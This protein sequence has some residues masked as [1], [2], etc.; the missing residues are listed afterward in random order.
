MIE[1]D[2][3]EWFL[4]EN[5]KRTGPFTAAQLQAFFEQNKISHTSQVSSSHM[6]GNWISI[7]EL[8]HGTPAASK[9]SPTPA[10]DF[11]PP[12]RPSFSKEHGPIPPPIE[13]PDPLLSLF[14]ALQ[15]AKERKATTPTRLETPG[16]T[17]LDSFKIPSFLWVVASVGTV[18]GVT[19]W[20]LF[21]GLQK[22][23]QTADVA[24]QQDSAAP[25][26][27]KSVMSRSVQSPS[28]PGAAPIARPIAKTPVRAIANIRPKF[29]PPPSN[30]RDR[31]P[32]PE[33][34]PPRYDYGEDYNSD[35]SS[36]TAAQQQQPG[37]LEP[38]P[39]AVN[40]PEGGAP[41]NNPENNQGIAPPEQ[42]QN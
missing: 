25:A 34:D 27:V 36:T 13:R 26:S 31:E 41:Q 37:N 42:T 14:D 6:G 11:H 38:A 35:P 3:P 1:K 39:G 5:G 29:A 23:S 33:R 40:A 32:E 16:I 10:S 9:P 22:S 8:I 21:S 30:E 7:Q 4:N 17:E 28:R 24:A 15:A 12:P 19:C 18:I 20:V 2:S